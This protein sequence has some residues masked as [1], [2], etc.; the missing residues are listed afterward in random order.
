[1]TSLKGTI[2]ADACSRLAPSMLKGLYKHTRKIIKWARVA[3]DGFSPQTLRNLYYGQEVLLG[4]TYNNVKDATVTARLRG[5]I[6]YDEIVD[7]TRDAIGPALFSG[8]ED[9]IPSVIAFYRQDF[10]VTQ[11]TYVEVWCEA[12]ASVPV[13]ESHTWDLGVKLWPCKGDPGLHSTFLTAQR[14]R[15]HVDAGRKVE[16]VYVGDWNP[17]GEQI[18]KTLQRNL[19]DRHDVPIHFAR[20][21]ITAQQISQYNLASKPVNMNDP[22]AAA[23]LQTHGDDARHVEVEAMNPR[24]LVG[25]VR[26]AMESRVDLEPMGRKLA[27]QKRTRR[28]VARRLADGHRRPRK[29]RRR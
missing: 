24:E 28:E 19:A 25:I 21:A 16:I 17:K 18:P 26:D 8:I 22:Q 11:P 7:L 5:I 10:W 20:V 4:Y 1:M 15:P 23:F 3:L 6:G 12:Q 2:E 27:A 13:L 9:F 14:L 29:G